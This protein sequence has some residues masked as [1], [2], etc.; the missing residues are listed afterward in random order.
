MALE[1]VQL[2]GGPNSGEEIG[3]QVPPPL[4]ARINYVGAVY[5]NEHKTKK[6]SAGDTVHLY[7]YNA[8]A[9]GEGIPAP[10]TH[11]GYG[12]VRKSLNKHWG[13]GLRD[14][15]HYMDAALRSLSRGRKVHH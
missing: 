14:A 2:Q 4:P 8:V 10:Q 5:D 15:N 6:D 13:K 3:Y 11:K 12:D 9:S 1:I 7:S